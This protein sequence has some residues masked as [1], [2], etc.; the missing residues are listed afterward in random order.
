MIFIYTI[1]IKNKIFNP[2]FYQHFL[3]SLVMT[4][5]QRRSGGL[6]PPN[7][8]KF[9]RLHFGGLHPIIFTEY[10]IVFVWKVYLKEMSKYRNFKK[11]LYN[12]CKILSKFPNISNISYNFS[13]IFLIY[14]NKSFLIIIYLIIFLD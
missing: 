5:E 14:F 1:D 10:I 2:K 6:P 12:F 13:K 3:L 4:N 8:T 9:Y 11:F 7:K